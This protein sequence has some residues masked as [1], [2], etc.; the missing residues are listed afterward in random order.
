[1]HS[2]VATK[3]KAIL[4]FI[5][6]AVGAAQT[7]AQEPAVPSFWDPKAV[8]NRPASFPDTIQFLATDNHPPF[9][10]RDVDGRLTGFNVDLARAICQVLESSCALR[11]RTFPD[12]LPALREDEGNAI[13]SGLAR[14]SGAGSELA[15]TDDYL[16]L[17][18]RFV[19]RKEKQDSFAENDLTGT[20]IAVETGS[21]HAIFAKRFFQDASVVEFD[22][23]QGARDALREGTADAHFGDGLS[24]SFWLRGNNSE[25]CC[26]FAGGP[27]LEPGYFSEGLSIAVRKEDEDDLE[28]LNYA[29]R[30]VHQSGTYRELY[31]RYFPLSFY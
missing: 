17:P 4:T 18:A 23:A 19:V 12:L 24:L 22:T 1:M 14:D 27:W 11:I 31:L 15:F 28:A 3:F 7:S 25:D 30:Q 20:R 10:F 13:I 5:T 9:V 6:V 21:R 26:S 16:K 8:A 2:I 29:L